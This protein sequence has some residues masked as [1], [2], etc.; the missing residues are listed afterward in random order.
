MAIPLKF[1]YLEADEEVRADWAR[2][3]PGVIQEHKRFSYPGL[4]AAC[5]R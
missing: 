3:Q 4:H 1:A 5:V 2:G